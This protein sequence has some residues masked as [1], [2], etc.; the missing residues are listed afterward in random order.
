MEGHRPR[1]FA[2]PAV[3]RGESEFLPDE[4]ANM[5]AGSAEESLIWELFAS[6]PSLDWFDVPSLRDSF[7][8]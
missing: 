3:R 8:N 4:G 2:R 6:Q 7:S 1:S 5:G